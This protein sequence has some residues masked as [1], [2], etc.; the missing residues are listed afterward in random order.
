MN[1]DM[2]AKAGQ[3]LKVAGEYYESDFTG[4]DF[5]TLRFETEDGV[6]KI[7]THSLS[8]IEAIAFH[9]M[10]LARQLRDDRGW[11]DPIPATEELANPE[12]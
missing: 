12:W 7:Y 6:I 3:L 9:A 8:D 4:G 2:H 10:A 1:V 5:A 11:N